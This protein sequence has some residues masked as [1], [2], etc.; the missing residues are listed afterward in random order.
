MRGGGALTA[1]HCLGKSLE[2]LRRGLQGMVQVT[3][4]S[5]STWLAWGFQRA[6]GCTGLTSGEGCATSARPVEVDTEMLSPLAV[7]RTCFSDGLDPADR[8]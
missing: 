6:A 7:I 5:G 8:H 2:G 1:W 3:R 4:G